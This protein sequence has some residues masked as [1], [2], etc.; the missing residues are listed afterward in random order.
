MQFVK[1]YWPSLYHWHAKPFKDTGKSVR[2]RTEAKEEATEPYEDTCI[3]KLILTN[4][5]KWYKQT[6]T[7]ADINRRSKLYTDNGRFSWALYR[8]WQIQLGLTQLL[9]VQRSLLQILAVS[10]EF[11]PDNDKISRALW[12]YCLI[13]WTLH[14]YC[15]NQLSLRKL[16]PESA[17]P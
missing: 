6:N 12:R 10:A 2:R 16:L 17:E 9:T 13:S 3:H 8:C 4:K 15:Q 7:K 5:T 11:Y 1:V 14:R